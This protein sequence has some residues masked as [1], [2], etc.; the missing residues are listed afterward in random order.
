MSNE[1]TNS[2]DQDIQNSTETL[3]EITSDI[4]LKQKEPRS[5]LVK[6]IITITFTLGPI[7]LSID[8]ILKVL[9]GINDYDLG[10]LF[11]IMTGIFFVAVFINAYRQS[12]IT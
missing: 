2:S 6:L 3:K 10:I 12:K 7:A 11:S 9:F 4:V 8:I 5:N 1:E